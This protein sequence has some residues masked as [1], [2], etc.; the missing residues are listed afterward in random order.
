MMGTK[1]KLDGSLSQ[2]VRAVLVVSPDYDNTCS[3]CVL[4]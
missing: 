4:V 2:L 1:R 3:Q